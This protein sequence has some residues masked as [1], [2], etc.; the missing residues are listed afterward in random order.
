VAGERDAANRE[1]QE[2]R[3]Q[4]KSLQ[5]QSGSGETNYQAELA[6]LQQLLADQTQALEAGNAE[7]NDLRLKLEALEDSR[8]QLEQGGLDKDNETKALN[9]R[10][11]ELQQQL[12]QSGSESDAERNSLAERN[13]QLQQQLLDLQGGREVLEQSCA[14][15]NAEKDELAAQLAGLKQ[16]LEEQQRQSAEQDSER[17]QLQQRLDDVQR[18]LEETAE[19]EQA[20]QVELQ[21]L[22]RQDE[23]RSSQLQQQLD[24]AGRRVAA[25]EAEL[26]D[27]RHQQQD[28]EHR[29]TDVEARIAA[30]IKEHKSDLDSSH[31]ALTRAQTE[32]ENVKREHTRVMEALR[33]AEKN[34]ER[35]RQDHESEL[36]RLRRELKNAAGESSAGLAAELEAMQVRLQEGARARDDLEIKLGER[37]A[38]LEDVQAEADRLVLQLQHAQESARQ[39]EQQLLDSNHAANEEMAVRMEA[40]E[41]AR[42]ALR[43]EVA[44][45]VAERNNAQEQLTVQLQELEELRLAVESVRQQAAGRE[46]SQQELLASLREERDA[47]REQARQREQEREAVLERERELRQELDQLRAEAEV[48]R[49]LV[50]MQS[51][52]AADSV[53]RE[54]LDQAKKNVDVAVRLRAKAEEKYA[55]LEVE[56]ERLRER[57][58]NANSAGDADAAGR[59]PS[60]DESDPDA[61]AVMQPSYENA[62]AG[63]Q[64]ASAGMRQAARAALLDETEPSASGGG[65]GKLLV[66]MV[67]GAVVAGAGGWWL[68]TQS[69]LLPEALRPDVPAKAADAGK[70]Q[71]AETVARIEPEKPARKETG[72]VAEPAPK[73]LDSP[74]EQAP[75]EQAR[76]PMRIPDFIK[77]GAATAGR[78]TA[79]DGSAEDPVAEA[80]AASVE[81]PEPAPEPPVVRKAQPLRQYSE[82]LSD[83]SRAPMLV[84]FQSDSFRMGSGASSANFDERP[85]HRVSLSHFSM[86][87][88]EITFADYDRF[89]RD[90]GRRLPG[91]NGWGRGNRPVINVSW[92]DAVAYTRWLSEQTG[93]RYRLP[94]EAEWEFAAQSGAESRFWWGNEM[95]EGKANCFDCGSEWSGRMTAP[96]GSFPASAWRLQDM[97]GNVMEWVQDCYQP[98]YSAAPADGSAA[99][100]GDCS[101]RIVRGGA[102]NSPSESLRT[103]S[104]DARDTGTRLDNLGFRVVKE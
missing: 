62:G 39:A 7:N 81:Q 49:G 92:Q 71:R 23:A 88:H 37:S 42:Q 5:E 74:A 25:L 55:Q 78:S 66:G 11:D 76:S 22:G 14:L 72:H 70:E 16:N 75:V 68:M 43:E 13:E 44:T 80:P 94:T 96:V 34:L 65:L 84:E 97:A 18:Q 59:I 99:S 45:A 38:Q 73:P 24:E 10:I 61:A 103:A 52:G 15:A 100:S 101:R 60:L 85:R 3:E 50:D 86:S 89:A 12:A 41:K 2:L 40:E 67:L 20:L 27:S 87:T 79:Y 29:N 28:T 4:L 54:Q 53:L 8:R 64:E 95:L 21:T 35:E 93:S 17:Q 32:T 47:A 90:T 31:N 98:D 9:L 104:R 77:G 48:T 56:I 57:L 63:Q 33:K 19:R 26:A 1:L 46:Q 36:Y 51:S 82:L 91:D 58:H 30:L 69:S 83:G 102:Y 6:R